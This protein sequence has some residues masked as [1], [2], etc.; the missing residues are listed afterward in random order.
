MIGTPELLFILLILFLVFGAKR[1]P[2]LGGA[3]GKSIKDFKKAVNKPDEI[4]V[5][6]EE[7]EE[8]KEEKE[9]EDKS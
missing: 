9:E 3:L 2:G 6:P 7:D 1:L 4:V 8:N 5:N